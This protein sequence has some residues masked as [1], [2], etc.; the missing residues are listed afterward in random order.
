MAVHLAV[1]WSVRDHIC[2]RSLERSAGSTASNNGQY[3]DGMPI[4]NGDIEALAD[5]AG[6]RYDVDTLLRRRRAAASAGFGGGLSRV[7]AAG[8]RPEARHAAAPPGNTSA[9]P[10]STA[11]IRAPMIHKFT[12]VL[13]RGPTDGQPEHSTNLN[14]PSHACPGEGGQDQGGRPPMTARLAILMGTWQ[15]TAAPPQA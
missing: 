11:S 6:R 8:P 12:P 4:T 3:E 7:G 13:R 1:R 14:W 5:E 10:K 15:A 9:S 2:V